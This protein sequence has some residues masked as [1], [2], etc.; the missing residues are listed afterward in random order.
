MS[1]TEQIIISCIPGVIAGIISGIFGGGIIGPLLN[2]YLSGRQSKAEEIVQT[3]ASFLGFMEEWR[4]GIMIAPLNGA[5]QTGVWGTYN[6]KIPAFLKNAQSVEKCVRDLERFKSA[7][8][9]LRRGG[10][11]TNAFNE[12]DRGRSHLLKLIDEVVECA[13]K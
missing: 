6:T 1:Q 10:E 4:G 3:R 9:N 11:K 5:G 8:D 12:A 13:K 2:N 7:V